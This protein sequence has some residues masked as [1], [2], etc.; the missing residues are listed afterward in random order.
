M[1]TKAEFHV[2]PL[3][4]HPSQT[5]EKYPDVMEFRIAKIVFTYPEI[6]C[7]IIVPDQARIFIGT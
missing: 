2:V 3:H 6:E 7:S 1:I 5:L 4:P